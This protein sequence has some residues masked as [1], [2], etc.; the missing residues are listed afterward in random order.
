[1]PPTP[2]IVPLTPREKI[3]LCIS[4]AKILLVTFVALAVFFFIFRPPLDVRYILVT[5]ISLTMSIISFGKVYLVLKGKKSVVTGKV[6]LKS[7]YGGNRQK[8]F[9]VSIDGQ[10]FSVGQK[11]FKSM[12]V[13]DIAEAHYIPN[14]FTMNYFLNVFPLPTPDK[15]GFDPAVSNTSG[16]EGQTAALEPKE[17]RTLRT[18]LFYAFMFRTLIIGGLLAIPFI[19]ALINSPYWGETSIS[20]LLVSR[21][22]LPFLRLGLPLL[23]VFVWFNRYTLYLFLDWQKGK[24]KLLKGTVLDMVSSNCEVIRYGTSHPN[25][26]P[27]WYRKGHFYIVDSTFGGNF[28]YLDTGDHWI[29]VNSDDLQATSVGDVV[30]VCLAPFSELPLGIVPKPLHGAEPTV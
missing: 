26:P 21:D 18:K 27:K 11:K 1:M 16:Y 9:N 12:R 25:R 29:K 14:F 28:V 24:K 6:T 3:S 19:M 5:S 30:T 13:G 23:A 7:I 8:T 15:S 20:R 4:A 10:E 17:N 22:G 2:A